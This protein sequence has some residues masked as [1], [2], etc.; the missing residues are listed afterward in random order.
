MAR[1]QR[2]RHRGA[3]IHIAETHDQIIR[4]EHNILDIP[5]GGQ[6]IDALNKVNVTR[7]PGRV[8]AHRLHININGLLN[9]GIVPAQWQVNTARGYFYRACVGQLSFS[10]LQKFKQLI[11]SEHAVIKMHLQ[12]T[13]AGG[14]INDAGLDMLFDPAH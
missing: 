2:R 9:R 3:Q 14:Q 8:I 12:G 1:V 5:S 7:T 11:Q 10:R 4:I 13:N 6:A